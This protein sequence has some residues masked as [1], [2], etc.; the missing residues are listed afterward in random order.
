MSAYPAREAR[1]PVTIGARLKSGHGWSDVLIR[2]VSA[3]GMLGQCDAPPAR[4]D[5]VEVRC[6]AYVIVARVA[7]TGDKCFGAHAQDLIVLPDLIAGTQS[8]AAPAQDRRRQPRSAPALL[9]PSLAAR[10]AASA[11]LG[12]VLDFMAIVLAGATLASIA[13]AMAHDAIARPAA[14]ITEAL[15]GGGRP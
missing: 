10:A 11:R 3:R 9:R 6:G 4:G 2:N 14:E 12:R 13:A 8:R 15:S 7:W 5:Y 1:Q